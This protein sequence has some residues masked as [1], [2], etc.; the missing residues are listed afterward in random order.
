MNWYDRLLRKPKSNVPNPRDKKL[1][2]D[3]VDAM[4]RQILYVTQFLCFALAILILA[5]VSR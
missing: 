2:Q 5:A 4:G 1:R 3:A